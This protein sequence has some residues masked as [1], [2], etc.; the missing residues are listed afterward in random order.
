MWFDGTEWLRFLCA[1]LSGVILSQSGSLTQIAT[2]NALAG[3]ATLGFTGLSVLTVMLSMGNSLNS[4]L[5]LLTILFFL[6]IIFK[7]FK[8]LSHRELKENILLLGLCFNLFIGAIFTLVQFLFI[9]LGVEFPLMIWFGSFKEIVSFDIFIYV[10][11]C[12]FLYLVVFIKAKKLSLLV[13]GKEIAEGF[14]VDYQKHQKHAFMISLF[15]T[16]VVVSYFG[17]FS[18]LG[19]IFPHLLRRFSYFRRDASRELLIGSLLMGALLMGLDILCYSYPIK[20]VELPV[21]MI[22]SILGSLLLMVL[23]FKKALKR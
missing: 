17:V 13:L 15:M 23:L 11:L 9:G 3:P 12:F 10:I 22:S 18:F 2:N 4:L 1:F 6:I 19:L 5:I 8:P 16:G 21:G 7:N 14:A 20:G